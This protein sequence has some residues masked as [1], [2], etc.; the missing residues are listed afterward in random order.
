MMR[1]QRP[2]VHGVVRA[3]S[4]PVSGTLAYMLF[5]GL[6]IYVRHSIEIRF[7]VALKLKEG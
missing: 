4:F 3:G 5:I 7:L 2:A 1:M 6:G